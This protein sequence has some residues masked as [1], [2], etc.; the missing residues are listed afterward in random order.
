MRTG[1]SK[2]KKA[3]FVSCLVLLIGGVTVSAFASGDKNRGDKGQ[4][5]VVQHQ[6][7]NIP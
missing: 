6:V 7:R 3:L 1:F 2:M 5:T 4:G